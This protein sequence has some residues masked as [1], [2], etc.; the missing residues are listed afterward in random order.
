MKYKYLISFAVLKKWQS[1]FISRSLYWSRQWKLS[2]QLLFSSLLVTLVLVVTAGTF[3]INTEEQQ[4]HKIY[5]A[6]LREKLS[7]L[8]S[9]I[10]DDLIDLDVRVLKVILAE[11]GKKDDNILSLEVYNHAGISLAE[12][13]RVASASSIVAKT[14]ESELLVFGQ[15]RVTWDMTSHLTEIKQHIHRL[16]YTLTL[17]LLTLA[18]SLILLARLIVIRPIRII[19]ESLQTEIA[20]KVAMP[21]AARELQKLSEA[22][23]TLLNLKRE[24]N[25]SE[26]RYRGLF[27]NMISG[28]MVLSGAENNFRIED[29]NESCR[30]L[31]VLGIGKRQVTNLNEVI[32]E[33]EAP[34][35]YEVLRNASKNQAPC[36]IEEFSLERTGHNY[37]LDCHV[38]SLDDGEM[39]LV[40]RDVTERRIAQDLRRAKEAA[41]Q[42]NKLKS[43]FLASMSHEIRTPLN[44]VLSMVELLRGTH[45]S[46]KQ[47]HWVNA[48][49]GSGQILLSTINDILDF[50]RIEAGRLRLENIR[51]SLSEIIGN[52]FNATSQRAFE[53][54]LELVLRQDPDVP[55]QL[56]GD[57]FRIQQ[58]LINLV[59]NAI[60]FTER[61]EVE[62]TIRKR[63]LANN[64]LLLCVSVRDTGIG[65]APHQLRRVFLPFEQG[66]GNRSF[67]NEGTG[68]GLPISKRL[69]DAMEGK[70]GVESS[71]GEGSV[72]HFEV[73]V[74]VIDIPRTIPRLVS[75]LWH[76][77]QTLIWIRQEAVR[78][79]ITHALDSFGFKTHA[80]SSVTEAV[81]WTRG[82]DNKERLCLIVLLTCALVR[83][84][85][86]NS[87]L[88]G[89]FFKKFSDFLWRF[90]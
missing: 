78:E 35:L 30:R 88:D 11:T 10:M 7:S 65:I 73:P 9:T 34:A 51:F 57:P 19:H 79:S 33:N 3:I 38:F 61:G 46:N 53:K 37:R 40:I 15:V 80:I 36:H 55:D 58:I 8:V 64:R 5:E 81:N 18:T 90:F 31:P 28:C 52:L 45:L 1:G 54:D 87:I 74:G 66:V 72:F 49:R 20:S 12:W 68:L 27:D 82:M 25:R 76:E 23:T 29:L 17:T 89:F 14:M 22:A 43:V 50:S 32:K 41:E 4:H 2:H 63:D 39:V 6:T 86:L 77:C 56:I 59:G 24:I 75:Q 69:V 48:I 84:L 47:Q 16:L 70:I 85:Q 44:G 42:A 62:I 67:S 13:K 26:L 71:L 21:Y 83:G 60:K